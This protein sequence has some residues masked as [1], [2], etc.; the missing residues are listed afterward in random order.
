MGR[1]NVTFPWFPD[2]TGKGFTVWARLA[3][4][5]AGGGRGAWFMPE[6]GDEVLVAFE[7]GDVTRPY[8][9]GALWNGLDSPPVDADERSDNDVKRIRTRSGASITIND[10]PGQPSIDIA[11]ANGT[12]VSIDQGSGVAVTDG[13][14]ALRVKNG[15]V[16]ISAVRL[17][18]D[19]SQVS[20]DSAMMSV[21]GVVKCDTL[22]TNS[23]VSASYTPGA[24][25]IW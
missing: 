19:A 2:D 25:N 4:F 21:S 10:G 22:I 14:A 16:E 6:I 9:I 18:I 3:Q 11:L 24:G 23:V 5:A 12:S 13:S 7:A 17:E 8:V 20:I 1:V 15:N